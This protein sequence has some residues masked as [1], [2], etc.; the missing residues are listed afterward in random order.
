M[1]CQ[2]AATNTAQLQWLLSGNPEPE[3]AQCP[4]VEQS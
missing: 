3:V 2:N 4:L 1:L